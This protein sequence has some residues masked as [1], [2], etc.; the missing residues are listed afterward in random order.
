MCFCMKKLSL[1]LVCLGV[2]IAI[3]IVAQQKKI[4]NPVKPAATKTV[5]R[6]IAIKDET[7]A[8]A[9]TK[10]VRGLIECKTDKE[11]KAILNDNKD[12]LILVDYYGPQCGRCMKLKPYLEKLAADSDQL[13]CVSINAIDFTPNDA[14]GDDVQSL[15]TIKFFMNT[16]QVGVTLVTPSIKEIKASISQLSK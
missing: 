4:A 15:P 5:T 10:A 9:T 14:I 16:K 7:A 11:F 6:S 1:C 12:K 8:Q 3:S 13:V 2:I